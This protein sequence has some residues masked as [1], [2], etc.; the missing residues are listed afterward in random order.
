VTL[1]EETYIFFSRFVRLLTENPALLQLYKDLVITQVIT[2]EEFWETHAT[3]Y[4]HKEGAQKQNIGE[5]TTAY[6]SCLF[7]SKNT[8]LLSSHDTGVS[9]AFLADIKPQTDGCNGLKYN[10]TADII[11]CIF[12]T[13]PAVKRKHTEHVPSKMTESEF[14][15]KFFQSHY[16]H[17]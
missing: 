3:Q 2:S 15:T 1:S 12:K 13:Y 11:D 10:L 7:F 16:F 5:Y 6:N 8:F 17:R 14:W 4:T 9:G